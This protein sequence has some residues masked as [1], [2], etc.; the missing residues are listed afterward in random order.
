MEPHRSSAYSDDLRWR[1]VYQKEV[2]GLTCHKVARN[3]G[4]DLST[5]SRIVSRF[6]LTG[7]VS[8]SVRTGAASKLSPYDAYIIIETILEQPSVYLHEL[9]WYIRET[10]GTRVDTSTICRFL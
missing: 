3:L 8:P 6:D 7:D 1:M 5:V 9:Q 10:T 2:L 4:V